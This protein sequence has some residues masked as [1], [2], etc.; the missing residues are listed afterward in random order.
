MSLHQ[1]NLMSTWPGLRGNS[2]RRGVTLV[3]VLFAIGIV[4]IGLFGIASL[5]PLAAR[6]AEVANESNEGQAYAQ[7]YY[8]EFV[9]RGLNDSSKW[10]WF[11]D[12]TKAITA[13][14]TLGSLAT[15]PPIIG[16]STSNAVVSTGNSGGTISTHNRHAICIDPGFYSDPLTLLEISTHTFGPGQAYRPGLFPYYH[17]DYNPV[18]NPAMPSPLLAPPTLR[19]RPRLLRVGLAHP[20]IANRFAPA[21]AIQTLF[22]SIDDLSL[23]KPA[24]KALPPTRMYEGTPSPFS[25]AT[26]TPRGLSQS[27]YSWLATLCPR[28]FDATETASARQEQY[29]TLSIAVMHNRDRAWFAPLSVDHRDIPQGERVLGVTPLSGNFIGGDGGRV[30]LTGSDGMSD[31]VRSGD[32]LMFA[33]YQDD[34]AN[35]GVICRWYRVI[36]VDG[37]AQHTLATANTPAFWTRNVVLEGP[38]WVFDELIPD[39]DVLNDLPTQATI[40]SNVVTVFE[41]VITVE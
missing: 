18:S 41:R 28:E 24:D 39:G 26:P 4:I 40:V 8:A 5:L 25:T 36:G 31:V 12:G 27:R 23:T 1:L 35:R 6:N 11:N 16:S 20:S 10:A 9:T 37:D 13:A 17:D 30:V 7:R 14:G 21:K 33:R 38:D 34:S 29:Y 19:N 3:E 2:A 22:N 15:S 32:W